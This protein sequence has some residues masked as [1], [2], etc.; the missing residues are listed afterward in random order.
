MLHILLREH[1]Y[2]LAILQ[3]FRYSRSVGLR[4]IRDGLEGERDL[5]ATRVRAGL[6]AGERHKLYVEKAVVK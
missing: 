6:Q 4:L 3:C 5:R 2:F 1:K